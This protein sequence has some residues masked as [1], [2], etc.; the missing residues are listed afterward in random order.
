MHLYGARMKG[1][2]CLKYGPG[3]AQWAAFLLL[4]LLWLGGARALFSAENP[5]PASSL[6]PTQSVYLEYRELDHTTANWA[7]P[8]TLQSAPFKKEPPLSQ[9]DASRG[10]LKFGNS[11]D[12]FIPFLLDRAQGKLYLD[13]NRN[14][15]LTD[16][17]DGVFS[18][19]IKGANE[20]FQPFNNIHL[21]FKTPAGS[22]R[23]LVDLSFNA[24]GYQSSVSAACRY[25]WEG[26]VVQPA[27]EWQ[28]A[29]V[30]N[31]AGKLGSAEGA[32][33]IVRPWAD[34]NQPNDPQPGSLD[35]LSFRHN[36]FFGQQAYRLDCAY[37]QQDNHPQFRLDLTEQP[38]PLGELKI[39]GQGIH[40]LLL[41]RAGP[42]GLTAEQ[43]AAQAAAGEA[44]ARRYGLRGVGSQP[45]SQSPSLVVVLDSPGPVVKVPIG[46]Y[47]YRLTL[48][49]G[50][51]EARRLGDAYNGFAQ[52]SKP[53]VV[54]P[55]NA[56]TLVAGGPLTNSVS[57]S[58]RGR[59]L[60]LNYQLLGAN[61][62]AYQLQ[63]ARKE[64][65]FAIYRPGKNADKKL[66]SG[67]FQFG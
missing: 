12:H 63:G 53:L 6:T 13:L 61:G 4:G 62:E 8:V 23:A 15:D 52:T 49:H 14:L 60:T 56:A 41:A 39:A 55:T 30:D 2:A 29:L 11:T 22:Y 25:Y 18:C 44:F 34:R 57:V 48:K 58:R 19:P 26:K 16:D 59:S 10:T 24:S 51:A 35:Y 21:T 40:R 31:L 28:L 45:S 37:V 67:K 66:A 50:G 43:T 64:P 1:T 65:E 20:F 5:A 54:N 27:M 7:I 36:L 33:L 3:R 17:P 42:S 47:Q 9:R 38:E 46:A 32:S